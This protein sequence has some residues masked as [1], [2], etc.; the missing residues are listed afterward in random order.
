MAEPVPV[1]IPYI[2]LGMEKQRLARALGPR[3]RSALALE[4][5]GAVVDAVRAAPNA[6][7]V[8][9]SPDPGLADQARRFRVRLLRQEGLGLNEA[10]SSASSTLRAE[11]CVC[12][13]VVHADLPLV[14]PQDV[15]VL[16][17]ALADDGIAIAPDK[18]GTGTN[19]I[20]TW[21]RHRLPFV[22]EGSSRARFETEAARTG[23]TVAIVERRGLSLDVDGI[24]DLAFLRDWGSWRA[25]SQREVL[26]GERLV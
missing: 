1:L 8:I 13:G 17:G 14:A 22:F 10:L 3:E 25:A 9:V 21:L 18:S 7:P 4:M 6:T 24:E 23:L 26:A 5:L 15:E 19:A 16:L 20:A 11:G 12:V 2:G